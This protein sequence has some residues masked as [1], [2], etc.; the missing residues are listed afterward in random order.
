MSSGPAGRWIGVSVVGNGGDGVGCLGAVG[1]SDRFSRWLLGRNLSTRFQ[2]SLRACK[3]CSR[4]TSIT[5]W[6]R[7]GAMV[8]LRSDGGP[9]I[10]GT[11]VE[12]ESGQMCVG[13]MP[14]G[15][16]AADLR[17]DPRLEI[18]SHSVDPREDAPGA[19]VGEAKLTGRAEELVDQERGSD[20][21]RVEITQVVR[22]RVEAVPGL[23][24]WLVIENWRP[25][26]GLTRR[27]R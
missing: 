15:R 10:S 13:M 24:A 22:T 14:G 25:E 23:A 1:Q 2:S 7:C 26:Q 11:E 6:R 8:T 16:R 20:R 21:F 27:R 12:V 5:R 4:R 18:H 17:R 3:G 19:W 9:R